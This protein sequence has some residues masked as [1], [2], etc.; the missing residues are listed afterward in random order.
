[1]TANIEPLII[2]ETPN[3][4]IACDLTDAPDS[5]EERLAE[6]GRLFAHALA[7]RERTTDALEFRFVAKP[8]L[9]EWVADLARR[10]AACCPFLTHR[11][12]SDGA[13][14]T[15]RMSTQAGPAAHALLD[16]LHALPERFGEG[17]E[18]LLE[19][20]EARGLTVVSPAPRRFAV[21]DGQRKP[22]I[23]DR[24]KAACGC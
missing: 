17:F 10:E 2:H 6:Y 11:V 8:G 4:P 19:R 5:P 1:M 18:A 7:G 14:V 24:V 13:H 22:G 9:G 15:W 12:S 16:E 23:L 20:F 21:D 3:A